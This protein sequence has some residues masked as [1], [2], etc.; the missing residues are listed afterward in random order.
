[1][2]VKTVLQSVGSKRSYA[3]EDLY[4]LNEAVFNLPEEDV[5][6]S[7]TTTKL[8]SAMTNMQKSYYSGKYDKSD[9][10]FFYDYVALLA[11]MQ[12]QHFFNQKQNEQML[13]WLLEAIGGEEPK[14]K[15][16]AAAAPSP[17]TKDIAKL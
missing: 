9:P 13:D 6:D 14:A 1:M 4:K 12:N 16:K 10:N 2:Y 7:K 3:A 15:G 11:T 8:Y 17:L 5:I